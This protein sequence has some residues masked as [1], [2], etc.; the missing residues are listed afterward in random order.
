MAT[1]METPVT[2]SAEQQRRI[3]IVERYEQVASLV[4]ERRNQAIDKFEEEWKEKATKLFFEQ[5]Q[6]RAEL[7]KEYVARGFTERRATAE[8]ALQFAAAMEALTSEKY[9]AAKK[10]DETLEKPIRWRDWLQKEAEQNPE[11]PVLATLLQEDSEIDHDAAVE[12]FAKRPPPERVLTNLFVEH[13]DKTGASHYKRG[14]VTVFTDVGERLDVK[15][16]DAR[17]I[18]AAL[19]VAAQKF[20]MEKGL[21]LVGDTAFKVQAAEIAGKLGYKLR[22]VEPEVLAAYRRGLEQ[23]APELARAT[24]PSVE[25]GITG[26]ARSVD[27]D[28]ARGEQLVFVDPAAAMDAKWANALTQAGARFT[29]VPQAMLAPP[30]GAMSPVAVV[31]PDDRTQKALE[32]WRGIDP[33]LMQQFARADLRQPDGGLKLD[34]Q[35]RKVFVERGMINE[36]GAITPAGVDVLL[37]RDDHVIRARHDSRLKQVFAPD[38]ALKTSFE[39]VREAQGELKAGKEQGAAVEQSEKAKE[40]AQ[41]KELDR[42]DEARDEAAQRERDEVQ[43]RRQKRREHAIGL[44]L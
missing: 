10:L 14:P 17:D 29:Q 18:E 11:D 44:G 19:K 24:K 43:Q 28:R 7:V 34:E 36:N 41:K 32:T 6:R 37:V 25:R 21:L 26:E 22:N 3:E 40:F 15:K 4:R 16:V 20:D 12:G 9:E 27:V 23:S 33:K 2:L 8:A 31:L 1:E 30:F 13:D 38:A 39:F 35:A 5:E 42:G